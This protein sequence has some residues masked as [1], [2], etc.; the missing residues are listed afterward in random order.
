LLN[1]TS[2]TEISIENGDNYCFIKR[3][4]SN[5]NETLLE[6]DFITYLRGEEAINLAKK[7]GNAEFKTNNNGDTT[8]FVYNDYY[9]SNDDN[10]LRLYKVDNNVNIDLYQFAQD[11]KKINKFSIKDLCNENIKYYPFLIT[12]NNGAVTKIKQIY[13]P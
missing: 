6:V 13:V 5:G 10:E 9:I 4:F 2:V 1:D 3:V 7:E 12:T 11:G 8:Y